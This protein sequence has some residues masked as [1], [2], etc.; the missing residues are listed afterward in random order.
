MRPFA[1]ALFL[2]AW[3]AAAAAA[4]AGE[5]TLAPK[6]FFVSQTFGAT[7]LPAETTAIRLPAEAW[8]DFEIEQILPHGSKVGAAETLLKFNTEEIDKKLADTRHAFAASEL[9]LAQAQLEL[10]SLKESTPLKLEAARIAAR[11]AK[12]ELEYFT[13]TRRKAAEEGA[14]QGLKQ[15]QQGLDNAQEELRQLKKMYDADDLTEETEE[16][17]LVRQKDAVAR[18][19]FGLRMEQL[20]F[21]HTMKVTLPRQAETLNHA[22]KDAAITLAAAEEE[23]PRKLK[24][25]EMALESAKVNVTRER[26][27]LAQLEADRKLFEINAPAAGWFYYGT[28]EDGRWTTGELIKTLVVHGKAPLKRPFATFISATAKLGMVAFVDEAA[29]RALAPELKGNATLTGREDLELEAK[30]LSVSPAPGIDGRYRANLEVTWPN[31]FAVCP[32]AT[33]EVTVVSYQKPEA[34]AVPTKALT[35]TATGWN[36]EVKLADGKS[37][38]RAV[39]RGRS[40]KDQTEILSGLEAGQV[41]IVP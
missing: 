29:A 30:L 12:E 36:V 11:N 32:G 26:E 19:E 14:Q 4:G 40:A 9:N 37:E 7:A 23:L 6:P 22:A 1:T 27:N 31:D 13:A 35:R 28:I 17:I 3:L 41:V 33:A 16:I 10:K 2:P 39:K 20:N 8:G 15:A 34:L 38:Q 18:A 5:I 24:L 25:A 21:D